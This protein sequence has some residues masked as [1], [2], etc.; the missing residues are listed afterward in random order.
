MKY[1]NIFS[2]KLAKSQPLVFECDTDSHTH[3]YFKGCFQLLF[4]IIV[5]M[6]SSMLIVGL[7]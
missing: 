2:W 6:D 4:D 5:W 1:L 7:I 3:N